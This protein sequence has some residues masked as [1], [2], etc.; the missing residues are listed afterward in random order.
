MDSCD[1]GLLCAGLSASTGA[2]V[3]FGDDGGTFL[4]V[5]KWLTASGS[6]A[7]TTTAA[8]ESTSLN[9]TVTTGK[10]LGRIST[11]LENLSLE[12]GRTSEGIDRAE[13]WTSTP[14]VE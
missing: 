2:T 7:Q 4:D 14:G 9:S 5:H 11:H 1:L 12:P 3:S 10:L 13:I 8:T 6:V